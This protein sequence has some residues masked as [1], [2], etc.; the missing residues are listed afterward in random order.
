MKRISIL[1]LFLS[2]PLLGCQAPQQGTPLWDIVAGTQP[3]AQTINSKLDMISADTDTYSLLDG[4]LDASYLV[5]SQLQKL[6]SSVEDI[7][8]DFSGVFTA[9][10]ALQ[11]KLDIDESKAEELYDGVFAIEGCYGIAIRSADLGSTGLTITT[12]G[13]YFFAEPIAY[14]P[15]GPSTSAI[16]INA[17]NVTI[18]FNGQSLRQTNVASDTVG[19]RV[20]MGRENVR[21]QAGGICDVTGQGV[22]VESNAAC[23]QLQDL[24]IV[25]TGTGVVVSSG[26]Q[27]VVLDS[28]YTSS[29][30][31][32]GAYFDGVTELQIR[33]GSYNTNGLAGVGSGIRC[34]SCSQVALQNVSCNNNTEHGVVYRTAA[35]Q[36]A[37]QGLT[38]LQNS[39]V[40]ILLDGV[41]DA[42]VQSCYVVGQV[43]AGIELSDCR[44]VKLIENMLDDNGYNIWLTNGTDNC[45]IFANCLMLGTRNLREDVGSGPNSVLAN[46]AL[47]TAFADNYEILGA[48]SVNLATFDQTGAFPSPAPVAWKNMSVQV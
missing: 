37:C 15:S 31:T 26:C 25:L 29:A 42:L 27:G 45:Y 9:V 36:F 20:A 6:A 33:N 40:G 3:V 8:G 30:Q 21:L 41:Q 39:L 35:D 4:A 22:F 43:T 11:T 16:T 14:T 2:L 24:A 7:S 19:I 5:C 1:L 12:P 47:A 17:D 13:T 10:A 28:V 23:V 38:I 34:L 32:D 46:Y 18:N 48:T 44:R